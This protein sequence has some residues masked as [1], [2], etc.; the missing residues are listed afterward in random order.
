MNVLIIPAIITFVFFILKVLEM[1]FFN[2]KDEIKPI[3]F[4]IRDVLFVFT[5]VLIGNYAMSNLYPITQTTETL[6]F[7]DNPSF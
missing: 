2:K 7:T 3:K 6:V 5:S 4:L 1:K